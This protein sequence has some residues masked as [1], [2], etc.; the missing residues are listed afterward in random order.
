MKTEEIIKKEKR[1]QLQTYN[2]LPIALVKGKGTKVWDSQ[3]NEYI[4][5]YGGHAVTAVGHCHPAIVE[6]IK[7]QSEKLLFYSNAVYSDIRAQACEKVIEIS[8]KEIKKVFFC[9]SGSEANETA[10]K[11]ARRYTGKNEIISMEGGFHGR[12]MASLSAT[13]LSK[14]RR[15]VSPLLEGNYFA[16]FGNLESIKNLANENT[17]AVILEPVQSMAG[18]KTVPCDFFQGLRKYCYENDI[19]LIFDEVQTGFGKTGKMFASQYYNV[20]PDIIT[21]A[22]SI[23]GG[24]PMGATLVSGEIADTISFGEHGSTFGGG[25]LACAALDANIGVIKDL[26]NTVS[27]KGEYLKN[28]LSS[29]D[30]VK[31][32]RG[33]G[34]LRGVKLNA[35]AKMIQ[36]MLLKRGFIV[37]TAV[38]EHDVI[39]LMPPLI[40][41]ESEIDKFYSNLKQISKEMI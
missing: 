23:A 11:I 5:F 10:L 31:E 29:I 36:Y 25:P 35:D 27:K 24:M 21:C 15:Q 34:L 19:L 16:E 7:K 17:A 41:G 4:D 22:K 20:S 6:A 9:N 12:T 3:G 8:P 33:I 28:R 13:G 37:G 14:Y 38:S 18:M 1:Y 2:K 26:L 32:V 40:V 30:G 39:R